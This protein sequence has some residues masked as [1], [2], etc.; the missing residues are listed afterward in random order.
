MKKRK[1]KKKNCAVV[2]TNLKQASTNKCS[3]R[4][5]GVLGNAGKIGI[6]TN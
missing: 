3:V 4:L 6:Y 5:R 1:G 2:F